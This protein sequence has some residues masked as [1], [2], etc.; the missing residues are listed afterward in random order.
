[1]QPGSRSVEVLIGPA[2]LT[3][4]NRLVIEEGEEVISIS[5][6]RVADHVPMAL[7]HTNLPAALVSGLEDIDLSVQSLFDR[8][9]L[10]YRIRP[11][12]A[13]QKISACT[14]NLRWLSLR[15]TLLK[16]LWVC[17]SKLGFC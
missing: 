10:K 9:E 11:T 17:F 8:L 5:R 6:I 3:V 13:E 16:Y 7:E 2:D 12:S 1:M 15:G 4:A 14:Q